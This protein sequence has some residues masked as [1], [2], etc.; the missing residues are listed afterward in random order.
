LRLGE[1]YSF[2][3]D[4]P[5]DIGTGRWN[6]GENRLVQGRIA[7]EGSET[8]GGGIAEVVLGLDADKCLRGKIQM[9][10]GD[11][12]VIRFGYQQYVLLAAAG[13]NLFYIEYVSQR[14]LI[15][16]TFPSGSSPLSNIAGV[17]VSTSLAFCTVTCSRSSS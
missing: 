10:P 3:V 2:L 15:L 13:I 11:V 7:F 6:E 5:D 8:E 9:N 14:F 17:E 1:I 12:A 4:I 16:N